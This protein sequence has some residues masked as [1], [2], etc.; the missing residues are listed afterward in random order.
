[1][2]FEYFHNYMKLEKLKELDFLLVGTW[3]ACFFEGLEVELC[4]TLCFK[5]IPFFEL[6]F[7][8]SSFFPLQ[9]RCKIKL[10]LQQYI[11]R[12]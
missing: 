7:R 1:M 10:Q 9:V 11:Q 12:K 4:K 6:C 8:N 3:N 5:R 2:N